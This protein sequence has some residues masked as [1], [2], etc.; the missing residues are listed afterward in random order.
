[1]CRFLS[2]GISSGTG[3]GVVFGLVPD[4]ALRTQ[5]QILKSVKF[6]PFLSYF[7]VHRQ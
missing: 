6:S 4:S 1:M 5:N 7:S 2:H 3:V